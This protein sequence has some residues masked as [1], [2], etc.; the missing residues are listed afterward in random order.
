ME[1][2][3]EYEFEL[4]KGYLDHEGNLHKKGRMRLATAADEILPLRDPQ[5][6]SNPGYLTI[7][8]L[9]RVILNIGSISFITPQVIENLFTADLQY[10]QNMY[11][12]INGVEEPTMVVTCPDCGKTYEVPLNFTQEG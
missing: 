4:P 7:I 3:T 5:V 12:A 6:Q 10:L 11:Q 8:L 1:F 2:R 9:S